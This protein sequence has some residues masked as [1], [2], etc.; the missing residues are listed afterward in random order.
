M[1][2]NQ[3]SHTRTRGR[4]SL[5]RGRR[6]CLPVVVGWVATGILSALLVGPQAQAIGGQTQTST[7]TAGI[8]TGS[9]WAQ[10][11]RSVDRIGVNPGEV[12][13][14]VS[15]V[16]RL[17][18]KWQVKT[19]AK[20]SSAPAVVN[21]V[22]YF[23]SAD[24]QVRAVDAE[25]GA[26][27]WTKDVGGDVFSSPAVVNGILYIGS[28]DQ[29]LYALNA[30][31]GSVVWTYLL[32]GKPHDSSPLVVNGM[33]YIGARD[34]YF[35]ALNAGT[36]ALAWKYRTWK[37]WES[38]AYAN[39]TVFVGSDQSKVFAFDAVT[40]ALRWTADTGG[41]VRCTP[42]IS[43]GVLY[44]GAD[45]YRTYAFDAA[46]GSLKWKSEIFP[47]LGIVRSSPAVANGLVYVDTGETV[48]MGGHTY[49]LDADTGAVVWSHTMGDYA[50][51]SPA[52]ANGVVYT[53][54]FDFT[55]YAFD[56]LTGE[57]LWGSSVTAMTGGIESSIA[58]V[59]G[60]LFVG[61]NDGSLYAFALA[62]GDP[63]QNFVGISDVAFDP[64][65]VHSQKLGYAVAWTNSG[66]LSH[67]VKDSSGVD[68]FDSGA[69]P[70]G[71]IWQRTF[72][73]ASV[74]KYASGMN[75]T[76]TGKVKVPMV[77]QP[78]T[79]YTGTTY[80][81][82]WASAPPPAGLVYDVQIQ[83]PGS[84]AW[85]FW[86]KDATSTG[87]AFVPDAGTGTYWFRAHVRNPATKAGTAYSSKKS[88]TVG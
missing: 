30:T 25:T 54:S 74:Y 15:N 80:T 63:V 12:T 88:I 62:P 23:G 86:K 19:G 37:P 77:L 71:T 5:G 83:R 3:E 26:P 2:A 85:E 50:T 56:A 60:S 7:P 72:S 67:S 21:G 28:N 14:D 1:P 16:N 32:G 31:D 68:L 18:V 35:Y 33:V 29:H 43:N 87:D 17:Q 66:A 75:G 76:F 27:I 51:S 58:V 55:I 13:L 61:S 34:G 59:G 41:R 42:S 82:T 36:G 38:A 22:V 9:D 69:I 53:G 48:P 70:P 40:G 78:E 10:F 45:D 11:H 52:V 4:A 47:N 44:V 49:A 84:T 79:G 65:E 39:G 8:Q 6:R 24:D 73:A 20:V 64:P 57:K 46:T 81:V